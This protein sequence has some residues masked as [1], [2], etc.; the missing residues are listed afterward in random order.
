MET[1]KKS[2]LITGVSHL[3]GRKLASLLE[4][5]P[6]LDPIIGI[7]FIQPETPFKRLKFF[8]VD[9]DNPLISELLKTANVDTVCHLLFLESYGYEEEFFGL[10]VMGTMDL[11]ASCAAAGNVS[12]IIFLS[13]TKVYGAHSGNP[14]FLTEDSELKGRYSHRYIQDRLEV[15]RYLTKFTKRN[16]TPQITTLRFANILGPN[17]ETPMSRFLDSAVVPKVW[18]FDPMM[19]FTH[20]KDAL[21]SIAHAI[22]SDAV[23]PFNIAGDNPIPFTQVLRIGAKVALPIASPILKMSY[24]FY[25][26]LGIVDSVMIEADFLKYNCVGD[27]SRMKNVLKFFPKYSCREV[28]KDFFENSR[29]NKY[30]APKGKVRSDPQAAESLVKWIREKQQ[31]TEQTSYLIDQYADL[32]KN[33]DEEVI[34]ENKQQKSG[35]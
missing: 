12:R 35:E 18:G 21:D 5:D 33:L 15:E 3:W 30:Y 31:A 7:D 24:N 26:K 28:I 16:K 9:L 29:L 19:Q 27:T 20:V 25:R 11:L 17:V 32:V 4:D 10:N 1:Q 14:N 22:K 8:Q 23:G 6:S 34:H 2:V 13:D